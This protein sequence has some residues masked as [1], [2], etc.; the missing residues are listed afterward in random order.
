M[1]FSHQIKNTTLINLLNL[2]YYISN[3]DIIISLIIKI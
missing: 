2:P 1:L 3:K